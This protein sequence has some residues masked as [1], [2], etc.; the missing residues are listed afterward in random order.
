MQTADSQ[1]AP[2]SPTGG[3]GGGSQVCKPG[4]QTR[5][6]GRGSGESSG[7][8]DR[9]CRT[10]SASAPRTRP[11]CP[12]TRCPPGPQAGEV[13]GPQGRSHLPS[14]FGPRQDV[15]PRRNGR[16]PL[17]VFLVPPRFCFRLSGTT[18]ANRGAAGRRG[19]CLA[20]GRG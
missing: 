16:F 8:L 6:A 10:R 13:R 1:V 18:P 14:L 5:R 12:V 4:V 9:H 11:F 3:G 15:L 19:G 2:R 7:N 20:G 17:P